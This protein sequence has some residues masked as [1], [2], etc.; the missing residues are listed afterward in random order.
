MRLR[1]VAFGLGALGVGTLAYGALVEARSL[2]LDRHTLSLPGWPERLRGFRIALLSDFHI[3]SRS[4]ID[5]TQRAISMTLDEAP[6]MVVIAGDFVQH[7]TPS[8]P[9]VLGQCLEPLLL[10]DS[11]VVGVPGNH[12]YHDG[13]PEI[14][15]MIC[16]ELNIKLL[17]N[18][19]WKHLGITWVGIDSGTVGQANPAR[20]MME[21]KS[22]PCIAIWHEPDL[23]DCLPSGCVL[24]LSGHSHGGQFRFPGGF[25]PMHTELGKKYPRGYYPEAPT[26]LYVSRGIGT[27]F[28]PSR[29]FCAPEV[30]LLTLVPSEEVWPG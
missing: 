4:S 5:L 28:L 21:A 12:D 23:V 22:D 9:R 6:D 13:N 26:P 24:Q 19:A 10:M 20:A 16:S 15:K 30:T 8:T 3:G 29:L 2:V 7:W 1:D 11:C 18:E 17:R 27:T 25:T 14:L